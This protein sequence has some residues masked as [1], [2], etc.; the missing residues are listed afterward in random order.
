M[1]PLLPEGSRNERDAPQA[2]VNH[3]DADDH[4]AVNAADLRKSHRG[5]GEEREDES[6]PSRRARRPVAE[7]S[8][9]REPLLQSPP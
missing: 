5:R 7:I 1:H 3:R 6:R 2:A 4:A 8:V 9:D